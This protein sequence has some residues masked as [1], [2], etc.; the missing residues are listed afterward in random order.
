MVEHFNL[1]SIEPLG[2]CVMCGTYDIAYKSNSTDTYYCGQCVAF[3]RV[4]DYDKKTK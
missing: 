1:H 3:G 4:R 2:Q